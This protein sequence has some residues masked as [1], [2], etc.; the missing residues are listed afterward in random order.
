MSEKS[1]ALSH[2]T[3]SPWSILALLFMSMKLV[4]KTSGTG[5]WLGKQVSSVSVAIA[6]IAPKNDWARVRDSA[7]NL[8]SQWTH[9]GWGF[10]KLRGLPNV[11][12]W[13]N[14]VLLI[15]L[16]KTC[17][18]HSG[19]WLPWMVFFKAVWQPLMRKPVRQN[20]PARQMSRKN[21]PAKASEKSFGRMTKENE[22]VRIGTW[23]VPG[24]QQKKSYDHAW[25]RN[26][27]IKQI[28]PAIVSGTAIPS[29]KGVRTPHR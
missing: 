28:H 10:T 25:D 12:C 1:V 23:P 3:F 14:I 22:S 2:G 16:I 19:S 15:M 11:A 26:P 8:R 9:W 7:A 20:T 5:T 29:F 21:D 27:S 18:L 17:V 13:F 6:A 24:I 4:S